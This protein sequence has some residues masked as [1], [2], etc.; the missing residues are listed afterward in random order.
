MMKICYIA[1][2]GFFY[3]IKYCIILSIAKFMFMSYNNYRG[4]KGDSWYFYPLSVCV[5][6]C[7]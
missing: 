6:L 1:Q 2:T 4:K 3:L 5:P 7:A